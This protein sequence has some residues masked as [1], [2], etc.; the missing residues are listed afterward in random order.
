MAPLD[1]EAGA[2]QM[3][4]PRPQSKVPEDSQSNVITFTTLPSKRIN[5]F[6]TTAS[7]L[8]PTWV[9]VCS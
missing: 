3:E 9:A 5:D 2:R 4:M 6:D 8:W 7:A 1:R